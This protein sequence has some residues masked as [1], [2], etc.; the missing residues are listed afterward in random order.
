MSLD[1]VIDQ[2]WSIASVGQRYAIT[3][4]SSRYCTEDKVYVCQSEGQIVGIVILHVL[5]DPKNHRAVEL[6]AM[7]LGRITWY[8]YLSI[9]NPFATTLATPKY[10]VG[11]G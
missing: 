1:A 10:K 11:K 8:T 9:I 4:S 3:T 6:S 5:R 2:K 7:I